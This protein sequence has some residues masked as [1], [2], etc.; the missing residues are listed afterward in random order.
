M[1]ILGRNHF[2][3]MRVTSLAPWFGAKR[4][5]AARIV[6]ELGPHSVYWETFCGS[7]AVLMAKPPCHLE[8]VN[9][10][11]DDLINLARIIQDPEDGAI[12]YR[13]AR[14][15]LCHETLRIEAKAAI[16]S[17]PCDGTI[18]RA[19]QYFI[20]SW[21]G[22]NGVAGTPSYNN[23]F[24]RR[25]TGNG[26]SP[27]VRL[28]SCVASIP[29]WRRRLARV[30]VCK[31]DAFDLLDKI[32]DAPGVVIYCDPPYMTKG[33]RYV[34]DFAD[35]DHQRLATALNRF[36]RTRVVVS[37]YADP[38]LD[39]LYPSPRW[40][41]RRHDV[42]KAMGHQ[43]RRGVNDVRAIEVLLLNGPSLGQGTWVQA[44]MET[45]A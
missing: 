11:H 34:H 20:E 42:S 44:E 14:R 36:R 10:L 7:M 26:G 4:T 6:A 31:A 43:G 39:G 38:R 22:R 27:A 18:E 13:R 40:T 23:G 37:Y 25:F 33:A 16:Q 1:I 3:D 30:C 17:Q 35:G 19:L 28:Q 32:D 8:T 24:C 15:I 45:L 2:A 5:M 12:F 9:D 29:A 41:H 21:L